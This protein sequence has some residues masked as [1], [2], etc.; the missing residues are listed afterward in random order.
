M[1]GMQWAWHSAEWHAQSPPKMIGTLDKDEQKRLYKSNNTNSLLSYMEW[2]E[3]MNIILFYANT[4]TQRNKCCLTS[5]TFF[6]QK[7]RCHSYWPVFSTLCDS[8]CEEK[9]TEPLSIMFHE[10]GE[11]IGRDLRP[12]LH[13]EFYFPDPWYPS[14]CTYG[15]PY[16]TQTTCF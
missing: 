12:F 13:A 8:S 9:V 2:Y 7:D 3:N 10:I 16:S 4:I 5:K 11:H 6:S 15:Q 1:P 14:V